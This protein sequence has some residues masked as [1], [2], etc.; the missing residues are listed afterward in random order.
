MTERLTLTTRD[1]QRLTI[2]TR[3]IGGSLSTEEAVA[4]LGTSE[5][6]AWRLNG[7]IGR[8]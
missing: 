4:L 1:Q 6:T 5:R 3:W 8:S 2:V 7:L